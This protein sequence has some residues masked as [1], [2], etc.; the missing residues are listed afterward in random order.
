MYHVTPLGNKIS[1]FKLCYNNIKRCFKLT[2]VEK[3]LVHIII[4][5]ALVVLQYKS[6]QSSL[7]HWQINCSLW[8]TSF[9]KIIVCVSNSR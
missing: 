2:R 1:L 4:P 3:I 9:S 7:D 8:L 6:R 5:V